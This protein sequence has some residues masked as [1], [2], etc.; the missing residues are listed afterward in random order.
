M[1]PNVEPPATVVYEELHRYSRFVT[2]LLEHCR[3]FGIGHVLAV[4]V[5][6]DYRASAEHRMIGGILFAFVVG[7]GGMAVVG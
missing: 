2:Y 5:N 1:L 3:R 4:G 6:L 7:V